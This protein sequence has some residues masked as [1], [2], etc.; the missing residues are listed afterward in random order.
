MREMLDRNFVSEVQIAIEQHLI[1]LDDEQIDVSVRTRRF[2]PLKLLGPT[3][4][5]ADI[6]PR[7][8]QIL[9]HALDELEC[10]V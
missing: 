10:V 3:S 7:H 8:D 9:N 2:Q 5:N 1:G 4:E 6:E